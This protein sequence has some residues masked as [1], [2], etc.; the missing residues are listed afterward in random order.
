LIQAGAAARILTIAG[1]CPLREGPAGAACTIC[2]AIALRSTSIITRNP[3]QRHAATRTP[4]LEMSTTSE[5]G[6]IKRT[7]KP[8]LANL[9]A[10]VILG[11]LL[12]GGEVFGLLAATKA[13]I[14]NRGVFPEGVPGWNWVGVS[15]V[16]VASLAAIPGGWFLIRWMRDLMSLR[17]QVGMLG[18]L[19]TEREGSSTILWGDIETI[20]EQQIFVPR[21]YGLPPQMSQKFV[22]NPRGGGPFSFEENAIKGHILLAGMIKAETKAR[23][24]P[25][26]V[27][28]ERL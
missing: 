16:W 1:R 9:S 20:E 2:A 24:V 14:D 5:V 27:T 8:G 10:G 15:M 13:V 19:I 6:V 7:F 17:V 28:E 23:S 25:W 21:K 4:G 26:I 22:V 12:I 18:L 3:A 11:V